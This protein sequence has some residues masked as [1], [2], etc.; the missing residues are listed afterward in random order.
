LQWLDLMAGFAVTNEVDLG[1]RLSFGSNLLTQADR[2]GADE[3]ENDPGQSFTSFNILVSG[4]YEAADESIVADIALE[5]NIISVAYEDLN[6]TNDGS[7][8]GFTLAGRAF[9]ELSDNID[10]GVLA[11][12]ETRS[13]STT[14]DDNAPGVDTEN[15]DL[16]FSVGVGPRY[17]IG[18]EA[19]IA[20][21]ATLGVFQTTLDPDGADNLQDAVAWLLPG[22]NIAAEWWITHWFAYRS[23]L[24][25]QYTLL[26]AEQ[27]APS[28]DGGT[29]SKARS[30][31][32][33]WSNG[34]GFSAL[35]NDFNFDAMINWPIITDGPYFVSGISNGIFAM[36]TASYQF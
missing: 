22:I 28:P 4:G 23:G 35:D 18:E 10:L 8:F 33:Y 25:S 36:V 12:I 6:V 30:L 26:S 16:A 9:F 2:D 13:R 21:Y 29:D 5:F 7:G 11:G 24:S 1:V 20:A 27:Q 3:G 14:F 19:T 15:S 34:I 31:F 17:T 32:F